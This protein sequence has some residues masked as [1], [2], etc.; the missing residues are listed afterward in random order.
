MCLLVARRF[1]PLQ[2]G[3][4][5]L[6]FHAVFL[7]CKQKSLPIQTAY[8]TFAAQ[9]TPQNKKDC[10]CKA[11]TFSSNQQALA[12][13]SSL[14]ESKTIQIHTLI[15]NSIIIA[16]RVHFVNELFTL[17]LKKFM[18]S[19]GLCFWCIARK[20]SVLISRYAFFS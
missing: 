8:Y 16:Q 4:R 11:C 12:P 3:L 20:S 19:S 10:Y 15:L 7:P 9:L 14:L 5:F 18:F 13:K 6:L 17:F 1:C 2:Y